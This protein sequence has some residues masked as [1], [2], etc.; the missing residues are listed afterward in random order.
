MKTSLILSSIALF[1]FT[2]TAS[3]TDFAALAPTTENEITVTE[4]DI[5]RTVDA[6]GNVTDIAPAQAYVPQGV[7]V[8]R[9]Q[10][11]ETN[12]CARDVNF[13]APQAI[14]ARS[15]AQV[16][17]LA[18]GFTPYNPAFVFSEVTNF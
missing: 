13:V 8:L 5:Y 4:P 6:D 16:I 17:E 3:A 12:T 1:A 11:A 18:T 14:E 2:A 15:T 10:Q 9:Q 7:C